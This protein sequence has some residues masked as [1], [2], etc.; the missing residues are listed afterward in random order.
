MQSDSRHNAKA[1]FLLQITIIQLS[2]PWFFE[3]SREAGEEYAQC[4]IEFEPKMHIVH[5][6]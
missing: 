5:T 1:A 4:Q 6:H 3:S 2:T